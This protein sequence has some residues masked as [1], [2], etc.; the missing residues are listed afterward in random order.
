M[1]QQI[2]INL[3]LLDDCSP[4]CCFYKSDQCRLLSSCTVIL[5]P[6]SNQPSAW[7]NDRRNSIIAWA[8]KNLSTMHSPR[9]LFVWSTQNSNRLPTTLACR[10]SQSSLAK[11]SENASATWRQFLSRVSYHK[12]TQ[13]TRFYSVCTL[14]HLAG[15]AW[16]NLYQTLLPQQLIQVF[17]QCRRHEVV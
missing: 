4:T 10:Q 14:L 9:A 15:V 7:I 1:H 11:F 2:C 12:T 8:V 16:S 13:P 6:F 5:L 17:P 3:P